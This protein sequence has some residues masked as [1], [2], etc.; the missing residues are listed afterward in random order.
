MKEAVLQCEDFRSFWFVFESCA[1]PRQIFEMYWSGMLQIKLQ[2]ISRALLLTINF[3]ISMCS[4]TTGGKKRYNVPSDIEASL[5]Q[6]S[7]QSCD[8]IAV[9]RKEVETSFPDL[10]KAMD[11]PRFKPQVKIAMKIIL[12]CFKKQSSITII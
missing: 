7:Q 1:F 2:K 5:E 8:L 4:T 9:D 6:L 11:T 10:L 12:Y 3:H